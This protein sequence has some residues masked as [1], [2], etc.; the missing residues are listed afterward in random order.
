MVEEHDRERRVPPKT[1]SSSSGKRRKKRKRRKKKLPKSSSSSSGRWAGGQGIMFEYKDVETIEYVQRADVSVEP[2]N[3]HTVVTSSQQAEPLE[4]AYS[5]EVGR[6]PGPDE[7]VPGMA[8]E[9][10]FIEE[11]VPRQVH[12][13]RSSVRCWLR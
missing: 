7:T 5:M 13:M 1:S 4:A 2:M 3:I 9:N 10:N 8:E 11:K 6:Y 12:L